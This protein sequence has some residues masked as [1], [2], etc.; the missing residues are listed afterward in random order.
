MKLSELSPSRKSISQRALKENFKFEFDVDRLSI[1]DTNKMLKKVRGLISETK[2]SGKLNESQSRPSY[3]KLVFME[4]A[5]SQHLS[6]LRAQRD[7]RIMLENE[8]VQDAQ[9]TLAAQEMV[10]SVQKMIEQVSDMLVKE[11]PALVNTMRDQSAAEQFNQQ[12]TQA[13]KSLQDALTQGKTALEGAQ[14]AAMGGEGGAFDGGDQPDMGM[15]D[16]P[17]MGDQPD[18]GDDMGSE[19]GGEMPEMPEEPEEAPASNV[20][21]AKRP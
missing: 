3:M 7:Y 13:L 11:L 15:G 5:L 14:N 17:D 10:D 20:G 16:M 2:K 21:R 6:D 8:E 12:A 9:I 18:M 1:S 4:Q 19:M